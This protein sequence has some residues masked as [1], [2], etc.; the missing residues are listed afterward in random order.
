MSIGP[1]AVITFIVT[2]MIVTSLRSP[3]W[4]S[5]AILVACLSFPVLF[6]LT[7]LTTIMPPM[8]GFESEF[9]LTPEDAYDRNLEMNLGRGRYLA[10][11]MYPFGGDFEVDLRYQLRLDGFLV[12]E[13]DGE[14]HTVL[15]GG[16]N[17]MVL[18]HVKIG[19]SRSDVD[20]KIYI[21]SREADQQ[22]PV[23]LVI[24]RRW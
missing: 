15:K 19:D 9:V 21:R 23:E 8:D 16:S 3:R 18:G 5:I 6:L 13:S 22:L 11:L 20:L 10:V 2:L 1:I 14:Q 12:D 24:S 17:N 7:L 4:R